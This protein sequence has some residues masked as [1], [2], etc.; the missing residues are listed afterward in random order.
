MSCDGIPLADPWCK[1][2][3]M[4]AADLSAPNT[5]KAILYLDSDVLITVNQSMTHVISYLSHDLKWDSKKQPLVFNQDGPGYACKR[6]IGYG[7]SK[8]FNSGTVLWF[9]D[10]Q[11]RKLLIRW[12][13]FASVYDYHNVTKYPMNWKQKWP[14]EQAP[15]HEIY[16][17]NR[18][19]IMVFSFPK[20]SFLPWTSK[21]NPKSQYPTD[22]VEP[23]CFSHWPGANCFITHFCASKKQKEKMNLQYQIKLN[24]LYRSNGFVDSELDIQNLDSFHQIFN[25][26]VCTSNNNNQ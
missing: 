4:L 12:W 25:R 19:L 7:Y 22:S 20:L 18:E 1:V 8:C 3:A 2:K 11:S 14:W 26:I 13:K 17:M 5:I 24:D 23:Y 16:E 21:K 9:R 15:Q 6:T 10:S